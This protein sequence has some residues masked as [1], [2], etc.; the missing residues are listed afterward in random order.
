MFKINPYLIFNGET[1]KA[2]NFYKKVFGGEFQ[3]LMRFKDVPMKDQEMGHF[4]K[5]EGEKIINVGLAVGETGLMGSDAPKSMPSKMGE[6]VFLALEVDSKEQA[7]KIFMGLS[8]G[9][10]VNMGLADTFWGAYYGMLRDKFGIG[11]MVSYTYP[12]K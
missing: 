1:E 8:E 10:K 3:S 9:G 12:K 11:W 5:N 7:D 6:N 4:D 2:F